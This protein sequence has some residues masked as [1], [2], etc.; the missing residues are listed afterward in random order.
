MNQTFFAQVEPTTFCNFHCGFCCGRQMDQ[1]HLSL[2]Q[3]RHFLQRFPNIRHLELQGEGEPLIHPDFFEMVALAEAQSIN[4]SL[5]TNGSCFSQSV[6]SK[7]LNSHI[8]AIRISLETANVEKFKAIRGGSLPAIVEN[9]TRLRHERAKRGQDYP[10]VGFAVTLLASTLDD[11]PAIYALY[12]QLGLDGGVAIQPLNRMPYYLEH[13]DVAMQS[14]LM[15]AAEHG[16]RYQRYMN[17]E[18]VQRIWQTRS[19][20]Q[21]FY[22]ELFKPRPADI[23]RG[24]L[25]AC[26]WLESGIYLDRHGRLSP[27]CMI[28]AEVYSLGQIDTVTVETITQHRQRLADELAAGQIPALCVGCNVAR[29]IVS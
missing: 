16:E 2:A 4:V 25:T 17:R 26:P 12:E 24:H 1:S 13:T 3:F 15:T 29:T 20:Y 11:L 14:E 28:K 5:I 23:E 8:R 9:I 27:C 18:I 21:H 10:S 7:I 19:S 22:D 6:R